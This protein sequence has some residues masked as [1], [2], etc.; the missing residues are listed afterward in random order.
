MK[1]VVQKGEE[2][3][4]SSVNEESCSEGRKRRKTV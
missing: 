4:C 3:S 2:Q 1:K